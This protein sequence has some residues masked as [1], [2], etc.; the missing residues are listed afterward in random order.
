MVIHNVLIGNGLGGVALHTHAGPSFG[1][2]AD[3]MSGNKIIGNFIARNLADTADT[4]AP[5]PVGI[6]INGGGGGSP[7]V[8][9][10][11]SENVVRDEDVDIAVNT[12][13]EVDVHL[14]DLQ[15]GKVGV[16]DVCAFD[17]AT[18]CTGTIDA[19]ENYWG[20]PAG[21]GGNG[22]TTASGT[23]IRFNPWLQQPIADQSHHDRG[24]GN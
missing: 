22:C 17:T 21:P 5:G 14:N 4:A 11:I 20:C 24:G 13:A 19:T 18:A 9:T 8:D 2:P 15:G 7:I 3:D 23:D 1:A 6:N 10:V 12:P 16:A